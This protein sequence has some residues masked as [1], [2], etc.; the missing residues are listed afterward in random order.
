MSTRLLIGA[1]G[2]AVGFYFGGP[3]G[4]AWGWQIGYGVGTIVDPDQIEGPR[5]NDA[6]T[7]TSRDGVPIPIV[8]GVGR[9]S[10]NII[11][12]GDLREI[13]KKES[14]KGGPEVTTFTYLR[15]HAIGICRGPILGIRRIWRDQKLVY[16]ATAPS[17]L[18]NPPPVTGVPVQ[19]ALLQAQ[20]NAVV[21]GVFAARLTIYLGDETQMPDPEIEAV[22]GAG[23][24]PAYRGMAY[25]VIKDD[26][27]TD[28]AGAIPQYEFEVITA[29]TTEALPPAIEFDW[30][31]TFTGGGGLGASGY[32]STVFST[33]L[34][35][36]PYMKV[37]GL[38]NNGP[39]DSGDPDTFIRITVR[40]GGPAGDV[41]FTTGWMGD[42]TKLAEL[43]QRMMLL[44]LPLVTSISPSP[45]ESLVYYSGFSEPAH[46][47]IDRAAGGT[48]DASLKSGAFALR[49]DYIPESEVP[50]PFTLLPEAPGV[51]VGS[52]GQLYVTEVAN[53][54]SQA[55]AA[56]TVT[57]GSIIGGLL[58]SVGVDASRRS[59]GGASTAVKGYTIARH[60]DAQQALQGLQQAFQF[61]AGEWDG[62]IQFVP[63]GGAIK[64][65][66]SL[67][68]LCEVDGPALLETRAQEVELPRKLS[69]TYADPALNYT[70]SK[71]TAERYTATASVTEGQIEIPV[72]LDSDEAAKVADILLKAS[73][74]DLQGGVE[75][76]LP[77]QFSDLTATD[78]IELPVGPKT[79]RVRIDE[80][81]RAAGRLKVVGRID[82][83]GSY[84][85]T[86]T[87]TP[88]GGTNQGLTGLR[89]PTTLAILDVA[90]LR[91]Q[92]DSLG[93]Y[94]AVNGPLPSWTGAI[95]QVSYDDGETWEDIGSFSQEATMGTTL[96]VLPQA[97]PFV[98]DTRNTVR[99]QVDGVL[100]SITE[101][102]LLREGNQAFIGDELV[103]FQTVTLVSPGVYDLSG[104]VRGRLG[105]SSA[106]AA[107]VGSRF[108]LLDA[109]AW[110]PLPVGQIGRLIQIRAVSV[111]TAEAAAPVLSTLF[112]PPASQAEFEVA[113]LS[114]RRTGSDLAARWSP[115][116]R[117]G[118]DANPATGP[119]L[120]GYRVALSGPS[121]GRTYTTTQPELVVSA[122]DLA[123]IGASDAGSATVEVA[124]VN[125]ITGP[126]PYRSTT[127]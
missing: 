33:G 61:D 91:D 49:I 9:V 73:W 79:Q 55:L 31:G 53:A 115:R 51:L 28:R 90:Q 100:S 118:V 57:L 62:K 56:G 88:P 52:D 26:D 82:R 64:R 12:T 41:V 13:R 123:A 7:Q 22:L 119:N 3:Q 114:A 106:F 97:S 17:D 15:T 29:G 44:S 113:A 36:H 63:R 58:D 126:G 76:T 108:V 16:D 23:N 112:L 39:G 102:A 42:V 80:I 47:T 104:L 32:Q 93:Y 83:T 122:A 30:E 72:V 86:A 121:G 38:N 77:D 111:G 40:R 120:T 81:G 101:G 5:L 95:V 65:T 70:P 110:V 85:S 74:N 34:S 21:S 107:P 54:G 127:A 37:T 87:G 117:L 109:Y 24:V 6:R 89:G 8:F 35:V 48:G 116:G 96:T 94:V 50:Q 78:A 98:R 20:Y 25:V 124:A 103:Q 92:D 99:V 67:A 4:A 14:G 10:G 45:V 27:L 11:W 75:F 46:V 18:P 69:V 71:Q 68:D 59:I 60:T 2:A 84:V 19:D 105:T 1:A 66:L 43:N 125:A